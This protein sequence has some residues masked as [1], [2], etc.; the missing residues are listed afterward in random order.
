MRSEITGRPADELAIEAQS[1]P[2]FDEGAR[3]ALGRIAAAARVQATLDARAAAQD[4]EGTAAE[5]PE[6]TAPLVPEDAM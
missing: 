2:V 5:D 6:G 4:P 3:V 1:N